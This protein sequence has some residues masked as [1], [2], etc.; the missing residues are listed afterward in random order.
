MLQHTTEK[1]TETIIIRGARQLLTLRGS[2][3]P[4][5]GK[6]LRELGVITDGSVLIQNG[7]IVETGLTRRLDNLAE[8]RGAI[9]IN[10]AGRVV[11]P[12]FVDAHTHLL[13][14][15]GGAE[16]SDRSRGERYVRGATGQRIESRARQHLENMARHGTT[17]A[18][19]KTGFGPEENVEAKLLR[20]L[21]A[22]QG[23][24][25][26]IGPTYLLSLPEVGREEAL[27]R[28]VDILLPRV[29]RGRLARFADIVWDEDPR[30]AGAL[31]RYL[32]TA[33]AL[34]FRS[35]VHAQCPHPAAAILQAAAHRAV[36]IDHL[37]YAAAEEAELL[38]GTPMAA[39]LLPAA[40][41]YNRGPV[42]PARIFAD[43]GVALALGTNF[44]PRE[45]PIFS[46]QTVIS[47]ATRELGL[48]PEEAISAATINAAHAVD[49][50][51]TTGSLEHGKFADL[52]ILN[53]GDY[54]EL[55]DNI[56][57]NLV[58]MTMRHGEVIYRQGRVGLASE[59][60][61][62]LFPE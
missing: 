49:L 7:L 24:P 44:N 20:V 40:S 30:Y 34:G 27:R 61:P 17:T 48:S 58:H 13:W 47:L 33:Q 57:G 51:G 15:P 37:E 31:E 55:A 45:T 14:P 12:G 53:I 4:R 60:G 42:P 54:R 46:M 41:F 10:A 26:E 50:A 3:A 28:A 11:M 1:P 38:A 8:A 29:R 5:R 32:H 25:I 52:L 39:T 2:Q 23:H 43:A 62:A 35:K 16:G 56:G 19:V 6:H 22:L 18:E 36:S 59:T 21:A 9:E